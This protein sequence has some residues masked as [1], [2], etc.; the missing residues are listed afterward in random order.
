MEGKDLRRGF[1]GVGWSELASE[2]TGY[3][4]TFEFQINNK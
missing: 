2:N 1:L 3:S 4:V